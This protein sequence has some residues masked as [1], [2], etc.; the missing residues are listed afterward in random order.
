MGWSPI[1]D[2]TNAL[3][4]KRGTSP[5]ELEIVLEEHIETDAIDLLA[6]RSATTWKLT[7]ELPG[8]EVTVTSDNTVDVAEIRSDSAA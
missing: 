1:V 7:F 3:A 6:K 5:E 8:Y 2:I 4:E